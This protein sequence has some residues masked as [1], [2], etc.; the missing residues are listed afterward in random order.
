MSYKLG[1]RTLVFRESFLFYHVFSILRLQ[2]RI[3]DYA[4]SADI[5]LNS[6]CMSTIRYCSIFGSEFWRLFCH[7][8][9]WP[10]WVFLA[11]RFEALV[12]ILG[13]NLV[14]VF[15]RSKSWPIFFLWSSN[16]LEPPVES[17]SQLGPQI[18]SYWEDPQSWNSRPNFFIFLISQSV[19]VLRPFF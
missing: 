12:N 19:G 17:W 5:S 16:S 1:A 14:H 8:Q 10:F 6:T 13:W 11:P 3:L 9:K 7:A 4:I 18:L 2:L 15:L